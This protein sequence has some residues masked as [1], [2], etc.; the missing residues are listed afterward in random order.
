M[1]MDDY[2]RHQRDLQ[3][4]IERSA[5][6]SGLRSLDEQVRRAVLPMREPYLAETALGRAVRDVLTERDLAKDALA[7]AVPAGA[8]H[9]FDAIER[10]RAAYE[11]FLDIATTSRGATTQLFERLQV[12]AT[13]HLRELSFGGVGRTLETEIARVHAAAL[14]IYSP[15][16][17]AALATA[18][19]GWT[20]ILDTYDEA[21][22]GSAFVNPLAESVRYFR[23]TSVMLARAPEPVIARAMERSLL[24][25]DA[26][27]RAT[28]D[29]LLRLQP[30]LEGEEEEP[31]PRRLLVPWAQRIE[32]RR[33]GDLLD[34]HADLDDVLAA[35]PTGQ[36]VLVAREV[37][38][39]FLD[40]VE[41]R[42]GGGVK[43][44]RMTARVARACAE[45][46]FALP[47]SRQTFAD[48][49]DDLYWLLYEA[50]GA[51]S[52]RYL[53]EHGGPF[54]LQDCDFIF[55]VK[56][57]RN[58]YRHDLEHGSDRDIEKKFAEVREDLRARGVERPQSRG[59]YRA[60]HRVLLEEV[61]MFLRKLREAL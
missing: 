4:M 56:R 46:P 52:L 24:L 22:L 34:E 48:F 53:S 3:R 59:D 30:T 9:L 15:T 50:P 14:G 41:E 51:R 54:S 31:P 17:S 2:F 18:L 42:G 55:V 8:H 21:A 20:S 33:A 58:Y 11:G 60:L 25:T 61:A 43:I 19:G 7:A 44:F 57:L 10:Q 12:D 26:E 38:D 23:E 27:L 49:V 28:D 29:A 36:V 13:R 1:N 47:V 40:I 37:V 39:L 45:L 6:I 32:L 5:G 16:A 35:L